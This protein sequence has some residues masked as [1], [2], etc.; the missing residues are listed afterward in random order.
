MSNV[1]PNPNTE[2]TVPAE[3]LTDE[4]LNKVAGARWLWK[5]W[6]WS[7]SGSY[8]YDDYDPYYSYYSYYY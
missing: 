6:E 1:I 7:P 2:P 3:E 5:G 8:Y 4:D